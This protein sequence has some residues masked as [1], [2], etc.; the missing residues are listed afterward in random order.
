METDEK[1]ELGDRHFL[2]LGDNARGQALFDVR[3]LIASS[4]TDGISETKPV[5]LSLTY[6]A[7]VVDLSR[8]SRRTFEVFALPASLHSLSQSSGPTIS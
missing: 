5:F 2:M 6:P 4:R 7:Y 8:L 1:T 3:E